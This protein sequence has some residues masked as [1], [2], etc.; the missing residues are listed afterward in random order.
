MKKIL[1]IEDEPDVAETIKMFLEKDG[2]QVDLTLD[3]MDGIA[4]AAKYDL[5]LLDL[6][7]PKVS[8]RQVLKEMK[9]RGITIP[10]IVLSAVGLPMMV[11]EELKRDF[12]SVRFVSKTEMYSGLIP[13]IK[14]AL[15]E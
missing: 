4:K 6:I 3:A 2:Y 9:K 8:G 10:V 14:A 15:K 12:P 13:A 11:G 5:L 7:M 1:I